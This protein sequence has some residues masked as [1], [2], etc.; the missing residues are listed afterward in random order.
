MRILNSGLQR[1]KVIGVNMFRA[2][3]TVALVVPTNSVKKD[4]VELYDLPGFDAEHIYT[5]EEV[6]GQEALK[7]YTSVV[8][9]GADILLSIILN[10]K[11]I[12]AIVI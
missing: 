12:K 6:I 3:Q 8:C 9:F 7:D 11:E 1:D 10:S 5:F 4:M 2:N